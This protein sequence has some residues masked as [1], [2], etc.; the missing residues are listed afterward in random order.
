MQR[1]LFRR[2]RRCSCKKVLGCEISIKDELLT[3]AEA[4]E[5]AHTLFMKRVCL[6]TQTPEPLGGV[7]PPEKLKSRSNYLIH[8]YSVLLKLPLDIK[9]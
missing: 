5:K 3:N 7:L 4:R 9:N 6:S 2:T 1:K 8:L